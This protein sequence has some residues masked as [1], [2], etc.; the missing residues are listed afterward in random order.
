VLVAD[1]HQPVLDRVVGLLSSE[2]TVVG[3]VRDG[4]EAVAAE[5]RLRPDVLILDISMPRLSGLKATSRVITGGS[6]AAI[7]LLTIHEELELVE[8][9]WQAGALGYVY[10]SRLGTDLIP[11]IRAAL[12]GRR[13]VSGAIVPRAGN[14]QSAG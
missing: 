12:G 9:A 1:D 10:K 7:I 11:A 6:R 3:A 8:A 4:E 14:D 2:F 13:F 5:L